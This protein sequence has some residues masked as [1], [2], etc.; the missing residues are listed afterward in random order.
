MGSKSRS[1]RGRSRAVRL[2]L[3]PEYSEIVVFKRHL[4]YCK[5]LS[6]STI[7]SFREAP[8]P[9]AWFSRTAKF[10]ILIQGVD[11]PDQAPLRPAAVP[12]FRTKYSRCCV[13]MRWVATYDTASFREELLPAT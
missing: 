3:M 2:G 4:S 8:V 1:A 7:G 12:P 6:K 5:T 11:N 10:C 9:E 13:S